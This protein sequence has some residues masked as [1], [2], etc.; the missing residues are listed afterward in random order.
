VLYLSSTSTSLPPLYLY[1]RKQGE[2]T[3][4]RQAEAKFAIHSY[5]H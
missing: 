1:F 5:T 3:G 2:A 4:Y